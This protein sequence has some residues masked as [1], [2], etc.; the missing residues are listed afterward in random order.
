ME[1]FKVKIAGH[2]AEVESLY[3]RSKAICRDFLTDELPEFRIFLGQ[4]DIEKER[5]TYIKVYG[6]CTL[7]DST[8]ETY[9]LHAAL[10]TKLLDYDTFMMH[11]AAVAYND[12][13]YIFSG[14]SGIGKTTHV[15]QWLKRL[16]GAKIING[17]KP[18]I[19]TGPGG[20][21]PMAC[22]TPWGGK[23][24][25]YVNT[26]V[27]VRSIIMMERAEENCIERIS[28]TDFFISFL[29]QVFHSDEE[30]KMRQILKLI[31]RLNPAVSFWRFKCNNFREDCFDVAYNALVRGL[32]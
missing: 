10:A 26:I 27:P 23:E 19:I 6:D 16:P 15:L 21:S 11:G 25:Y 18:F 8:L 4:Q 32:E 7:W 12:N 31:Q 17:D 2:V 9:A 30:Q 13:T 3:V 5:D 20:Q 1:K 14:R 24:N 29:P 22:G 28:F